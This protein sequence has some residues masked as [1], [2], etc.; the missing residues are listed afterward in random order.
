VNPS[1]LKSPGAWR[2]KLQAGPPLYSN[3]PPPSPLSSVYQADGAARNSAVASL[4]TK[5][6]S[7]T[8]SANSNGGTQSAL[9]EDSPAASTSA[10]P[11]PEST[12]GMRESAA[13]RQRAS[14]RIPVWRQRSDE[15]L[16]S[17]DEAKV[18]VQL[19]ST[20]AGVSPCLAREMITGALLAVSDDGSSSHPAMV[21]QQGN[22]KEGDNTSADDEAASL[23]LHASAR[24][25]SLQ[26]KDL[27]DKLWKALYAQWAT[28]MHTV[29]SG[30]TTTSTASSSSSDTA[31]TTS[32][33]T[34]A[35]PLSRARMLLD[36]KSGSSSERGYKGYSVVDF[37]HYCHIA[38]DSINDDDEMKKVGD[39]SSSS[40]IAPP[41]SLPSAATP[42]KPL[43]NDKASVLGAVFHY[44]GAQQRYNEFSALWSRAMARAKSVCEKL[45]NRCA[46]TYAFNSFAY[47][48]LEVKLV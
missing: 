15:S 17:Q 37:K 46:V 4:F 2:L 25:S 21:T 36:H 27:D 23:Y 24:A 8:T 12:N 38:D 19:Y 34:A 40:L 28:W 44:Y 3:V 22:N 32:T 10:A 18:A 48:C 39:S 13:A 47:Q 9:I 45:E 30:T 7:V 33:S 5:P 29:A 16:G 20:F 31:S 43:A 1:S 42:G 6:L 41:P 14:Q 26:M 11:L 35:A